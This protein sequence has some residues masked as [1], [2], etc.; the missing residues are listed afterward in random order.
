MSK[1]IR[2]YDIQWDTTKSRSSSVIDISP[3]LLKL[4]LPNSIDFITDNGYDP[5][6]QLA[7]TLSGLYGYCIF[8]CQWEEICTRCK[9]A[10]R[11]LL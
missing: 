5:E 4:G 9:R 7:D 6:N 10:Y 11:D 8:G 3:K 1:L 2:A